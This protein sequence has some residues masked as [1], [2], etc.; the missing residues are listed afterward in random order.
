M[1]PRV[2]LIVDL[3]ACGAQASTLANPAILQAWGGAQT[4]AIFQAWEAKHGRTYATAAERIRRRHLFG[5]NLHE[6]QRLQRLSPLATYAPDAFADYTNEER[7]ALTSSPGV[8]GHGVAS[9]D[10]APIAMTHAPNEGVERVAFTD[11]Q[12]AAALAAGPLDWRAKGAVTPATSQGRCSTCA[13]FAGTAAVEGAWKLAGHPLVK[14]SEQEEI[15]CYNNGGYAMPN[16]VN[17]IARIVDAPLANHRQVIVQL[18]PPAP[19]SYPFPS[20]KIHT[21]GNVWSF[22]VR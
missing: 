4:P 8:M 2:A 19:P 11:V 17:G 6:L 13:Y 15:D 9:T 10:H 3:H 14:L 21:R 1:R 7:V 22:T 20:G 18:L 5:A 16:M 12:R